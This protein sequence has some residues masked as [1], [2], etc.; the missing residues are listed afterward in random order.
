MVHNIGLVR[1]GFDLL[2]GFARD[3][4]FPAV[5]AALNRASAFFNDTGVSLDWR[6]PGFRVEELGLPL[7]SPLFQWEV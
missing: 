3:R 7:C 2:P 1:V 5:D 4:R 6:D